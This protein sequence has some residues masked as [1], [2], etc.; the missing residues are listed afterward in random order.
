M[1]ML[2]ENQR[3]AQQADQAIT[4]ALKE[5]ESTVSELTQITGFNEMRV[6]R[7]LARLQESGQVAKDGT[8]FFLCDVKAGDPQD[9]RFPL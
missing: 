4:E 5:S 8:S 9:T 1:G 3:Q 7:S 6:R 2:E